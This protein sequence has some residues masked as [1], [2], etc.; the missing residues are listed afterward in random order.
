MLESDRALKASI[1]G[2]RILAVV[3]SPEWKEIEKIFQAEYESCFNKLMD[4]KNADLGERYLG[5]MKSIENIIAKINDDAKYGIEMRR[6]LYDQKSIM[7]SF[8]RD[9]A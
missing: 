4:V 9:T 6:Q 8:N 3:R 7:S 1:K 2:Q 5:A